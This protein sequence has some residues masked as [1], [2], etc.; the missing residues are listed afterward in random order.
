MDLGGH[1]EQRAAQTAAGGAPTTS[2]AA[3]EDFRRRAL[4]VVALV[5][6]VSSVLFALTLIAS[7]PVVVLD[8]ALLLAIVPVHLTVSV[9]TRRAA[10]LPWVPTAYIVVIVLLSAVAFADSAGPE[11]D[12]FWLLL[13]PVALSGIVHDGRRHLATMV[14]VVAA[15]VAASLLGPGIALE[16][17]FPRTVAMILTGWGMWTVVDRLDDALRTAD[18]ARRAADE[19]RRL[20]ESHLAAE[21]RVTH[22]LKELD[23]LKDDFVSTASHELRTP[24]TVILGLISTLTARWEDLDGAARLELAERVEKHARA[25]ESIVATLLDTARIERG[26]LRVEVERVVLHEVVGQSLVRLGPVLRE[27]DVRSDLAVDTVVLA[28]PRLL[29]RVLDN[30]LANAARHTPAGTRVEVRTTDDE[31]RVRVEVADHG[32]G[33]HEDEVA[34]LGTPFYRGADADRRAREGVGLGLALASRV[35][36]LHGSRLEIASR[37]GHGAT[38]S[39]ALP[40]WSPGMAQEGPVPTRR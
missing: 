25:L 7:P 2:S 13:V 14:G 35:L 20:A 17:L 9:A 39:F 23:R 28:D 29:E 40:R 21:R 16:F 4:S 11:S 3:L 5:L 27:H 26:G 37:P 30:L 33:I 8:M 34:R 19:A 12:N 15:Y 22:R 31:E 6:A 32:P 18:D 38:F 36:D 1:V 24:L 10:P